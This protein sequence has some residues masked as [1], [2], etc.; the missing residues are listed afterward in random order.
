MRIIHILNTNRYSG[1]ENVAITIINKM[2]KNNDIIYVSPDGPIREY[3]DENNIK[4]ESIKKINIS[5]LRRI[6]KKYNPDVIH[7]HDFTASIVSSLVCGK[8]KL[9]SHIH[10]N[11]KWLKKINIYSL[12]YL[13]SSIKYNKILLVSES[14]IKEYIFGRFIKKKIEVVGNPIDTNN[15]IEKSDEFEE[16]E[17]NDII[18]LGRFTEAKNPVK[19]INIIKEIS[20]NKKIKAVMV[21][22][23]ELKAEC[24]K[25]INQYKL[26]N[27]IEIKDFKKNPYPIL[28]KSKILC[29]TSEWEGYGLVAI[30]ALSLSKPVVATNVGGIPTIVTEECGLV[31]SDIN[32]M[33]KE[34]KKL[35]NNSQYYQE[36][37]Q[38]ALERAKK[39]NNI[40][41]YISNLSK[42]YMN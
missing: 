42:L 9:I 6:I 34:I 25:L 40:N 15:I 31:T 20:K 14:I 21:G 10:N 11:V 1:A 39:L 37:S 4:F 36:K 23:G 22:E 32:S 27:V 28:K 29:M 38:K 5:E 33:I 7:A 3:L 8:I 35:L 24:R 2:K 12:L 16:M 41:I 19:F 17:N 26:E 18:F 13:I 30:E